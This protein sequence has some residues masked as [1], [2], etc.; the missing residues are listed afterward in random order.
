[1]A[2]R[3]KMKMA[4]GVDA[5]LVQTEHDFKSKM[6]GIPS[7]STCCEMNPRC[8]ARMLNGEAVCSK[9]FANSLM[10]VRKGIK[11]TTGQNFAILNAKEIEEAPKLHWTPKALAI[12]PHRL[13]RIESFGDVASVLQAA[14]YIRIARGNTDCKWA[15]WSKNDDLWCEAFERYGKPKNLKY[16][17]SSLKINV[18]DEIPA[19]YLKWVD[20]RFTV[21][22]EEYLLEHGIKSNCA[23][24]SC[25]SCENCYED[26]KPF[27]IIEKLR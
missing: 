16:I 18:P 1:M 22:T 5:T 9:C 24:I 25:V 17:H 7:I 14:N 12:N 2:Y 15:A 27:D 6:A 4:G 3:L 21:Y 19:K 8:V 23:G 10:K 13:S 11:L 20:H 26:D